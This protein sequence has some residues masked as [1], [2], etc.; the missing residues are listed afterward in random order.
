MGRATYSSHFRL[1]LQAIWRKIE[2]QSRRRLVAAQ[3][4][5]SYEKTRLLSAWNTITA[6]PDWHEPN[7]LF[8]ERYDSWLA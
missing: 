5:L 1:V 7:T 3:L 6:D 8:K 2:L 4:G